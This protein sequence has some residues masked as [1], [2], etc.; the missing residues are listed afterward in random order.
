MGKREAKKQLTG[1][2]RNIHGAIWLIGLAILFWRGWFWPGI[3]VLIALS[4]IIEV[5]VMKLVPDSYHEELSEEIA[6][7]APNPVGTISKESDPVT[8][9]ELLPASCPKCGAPV[10]GHEVK[11]T[12]PFSADCTFC[13]AVLP[14][15][16]EK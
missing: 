14:A 6:E 3:L 11:W 7:A 9:P 8:H 4:T 12:S 5:V 2:W 10:R 1:P 13:G 15:K 16:K